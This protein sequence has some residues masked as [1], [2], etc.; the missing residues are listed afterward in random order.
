MRGLLACGV[1]VDSVCLPEKAD[2]KVGPD[3]SDVLL[4]N[5]SAYSGGTAWVLHP[6]PLITRL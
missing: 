4:P 2:L 1:F 3:P 6:L 5:L